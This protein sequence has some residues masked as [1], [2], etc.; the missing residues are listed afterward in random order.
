[1][2][3]NDAVDFDAYVGAVKATEKK[4]TQQN[5]TRKGFK[6]PDC[7]AIGDKAIV[8]FVN[9]IAETALDQGKP[10]SGRAKLFNIGWVRDDEN[11]P[12]FLVLPAILN[13]KPM[14]KS[15]IVDFIDKVL[16]RA[17]VDNPNAKE[18]EPAGAW[19]YYYADRDDYGQQQ[20]GT[21]TLKS[22]FWNVFKSGVTAAEVGPDKYKKQRSWRGQT[23][24]IANVIDRYDYKWHQE[25]KKTKLLMRFVNVTSDK[26]TRREASF[27]A[28]GAPLKELTDNHGVDLNYDVLIVPGTESTDKF[29][30]K[31]VTKLK[32]INYWDEV[33]NYIT[34][35][36][37][38]VISDSSAFTDEEKTWSPIDIDEFYR[39]TGAKVFLSHF[40]KTVK[41]FDLMTGTNYYEQFEAEAKLED[42]AA[43]KTEAQSAPAQTQEQPAA[44]NTA[45]AQTQAAPVQEQP[46]ATQAA[47]AQ[48]QP[49]AQTQAAPAQAAPTQSPSFDTMSPAGVPSEVTPSA[50]AKKNIDDFYDSLDDDD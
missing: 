42:K 34:D 14:Y 15:L 5:N 43:G 13:N 47:P 36:D 24:Y 44:T 23:V 27:Y 39:L 25:N 37:K 3:Q 16:A 20:T 4:Q 30:L 48:P 8:R 41:A 45:P 12:F 2:L 6:V 1:M 19:Q 26:V 49:V 7:C 17:W 29:T 18:G 40:G 9:G 21:K 38:K 50:D 33:K 22:I 35:E 31:N 46:A 32:Q 10:G 28:M 11:K